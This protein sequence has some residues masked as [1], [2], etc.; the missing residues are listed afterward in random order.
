MLFLPKYLLAVG[1][2]R[3]SQLR[4]PK[5]KAKQKYPSLVVRTTTGMNYQI[6]VCKFR[7]YPSF[8][9]CVCWTRVTSQEHVATSTSMEA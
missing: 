3:G 2:P 4:R 1:T 9:I 8:S 7:H 5:D 6:H